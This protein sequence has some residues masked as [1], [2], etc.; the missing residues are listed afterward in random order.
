MGMG[1]NRRGGDGD[2]MSGMG[3]DG[4]EQGGDGM[5]WDGIS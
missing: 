2:G 3:W 4:M 1:S 5:G